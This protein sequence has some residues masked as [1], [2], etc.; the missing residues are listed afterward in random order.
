MES[1]LAAGGEE[2]IQAVQQLAA[3]QAG[4]TI[5]L[6]SFWKFNRGREVFLQKWAKVWKENSLDVLICPGSRQVAPAHNHYGVP[7]YTIPWNF[8]DVSALQT[9]PQVYANEVYTLLIRSQFPA[10]VI[11]FGKVDK[12]LDNVPFEPG[13][14]PLQC[15]C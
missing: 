9:L 10:S 5:D 7:V 8:L 15:M 1:I 14:Y 11:P 6:N 2:P 3:L 12:S 13:V 4:G